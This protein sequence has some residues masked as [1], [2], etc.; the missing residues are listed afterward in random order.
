ML[1]LMTHAG[2]GSPL[3]DAIAALQITGSVPAAMMAIAGP[4]IFFAARALLQ[5]LKG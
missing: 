3:S 5:N 4:P 2:S 1:K